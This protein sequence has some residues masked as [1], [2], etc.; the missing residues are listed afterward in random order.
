MK[1]LVEILRAVLAALGRLVGRVVQT[2]KR[3]GGKLVHG[4]ELLFERVFDT[5]VSAPRA[6]VDIG[7]ATLKLGTGIVSDVA[8]A[9]FRLAGMV[10]GG[11]R[12]PQQTAQSAA[13][14]EAAAQ[15]AAAQDEANRQAIADR[16]AEARELVS[17]VRSV[18]AARARR[19]RLDDVALQRLPEPVRD[20]LL[21]LDRAECG[22]VA[23]ASVM[24]LRAVL[25]GRP[26]E[27]VRSPKEIQESAGAEVISKEQV[28]A[29]RAEVRAATRA[30]MR[31]GREP[32]DDY[33][34]TIQNVATA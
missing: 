4:S 6:V 33:E 30:A 7:A 34:A 32:Q 9:P 2:T 26:P 28:A 3:I 22:T 1:N 18:A 27:G 19:E 25:K 15:R 8:K 21:A 17:A 11:R 16:Q 29:R 31:S 14:D 5:V 13:A 23:A 24:G 12:Q 10:L 20:Y